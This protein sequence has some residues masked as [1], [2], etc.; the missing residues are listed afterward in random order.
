MARGRLVKVNGTPFVDC[1]MS[2]SNAMIDLVEH[3][4]FLVEFILKHV[5]CVGSRRATPF[6]HTRETDR[7]WNNMQ[8]YVP[9]TVMKC[10]FVSDDIES[11]VSGA[12]TKATWAVICCELE[13]FGDDAAEFVGIMVDTVIGAS[14]V[15]SDWSMGTTSMIDTPSE[16]VPA[17]RIYF[18]CNNKHII[19]VELIQS[20]WPMWWWRW[21]TWVCV[22]KTWTPFESDCVLWLPVVVIETISPWV[23]G[24][25]VIVVWFDCTIDDVDIWFAGVIV[26][27]LLCNANCVAIS[28]I[29]QFNFIE[30]CPNWCGIWR[31]T[32][33]FRSNVAGQIEAFF[34]VET[35]EK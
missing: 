19:K 8:S 29:F 25:E 14:S 34:S 31:S 6:V 1:L 13:L 22:A 20:D 11:T 5:L 23:V 7:G 9:L 2:G 12:W 27:K 4:F 17:W 15:E 35:G 32:H 33:L 18:F 26:T 3:N 28:Q 24:D 30:F 21:F 16:V 10:G